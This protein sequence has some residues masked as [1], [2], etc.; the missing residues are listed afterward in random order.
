MQKTYA[1][2]FY[3]LTM[4]CTGRSYRHACTHCACTHTHTHARTHTRMHTLHTHI[5]A[6]TL[7]THCTHTHTHAHTHTCTHTHTHTC[8]HVRTH[9]APCI[10]QM[11][12]MEQAVILQRLRRQ[13]WMVHIDLPLFPQ[14]WDNLGVSPLTIQWGWMGRFTGQTHTTKQLSLLN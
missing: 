8:T 3:F 6:H 10:G 14:S 2:F 13:T 11:L 12:V 4:W 7:H 9:T 1:C 5:H